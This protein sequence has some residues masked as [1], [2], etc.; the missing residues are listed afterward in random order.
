MIALKEA[1]E[2]DQTF[3]DDGHFELSSCVEILSGKTQRHA[4]GDSHDSGFTS[5]TSYSLKSMGMCAKRGGLLHNGMLFM[6]IGR[7]VCDE[8]DCVQCNH[9]PE[10][11]NSRQPMKLATSKSYNHVN[12]LNELHIGKSPLP[13]Q[14]VL[15]LFCEQLR[16]IF[17]GPATTANCCTSNTR[18]NDLIAANYRK[19]NGSASFLLSFCAFLFLLNFKQHHVISRAR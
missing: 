2:D 3:L 13:V 5:A 11:C 18:R 9:P 12:K 8:V 15:L 14:F 4:S 16:Q 19:R 17:N 1:D 7:S 10:Y 6:S